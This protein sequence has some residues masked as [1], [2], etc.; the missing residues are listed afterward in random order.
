MLHLIVVFDFFTSLV[1]NNSVVN[2]KINEGSVILFCDTVISHMLV[3][4]IEFLTNDSH[5]F[6]T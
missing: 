6:D 5:I 2:L 3:D 1:V 4:F